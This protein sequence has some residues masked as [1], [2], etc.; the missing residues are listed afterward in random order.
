VLPSRPAH[1]D[2]PARNTGAVGEA[3]FGWKRV[4]A[5]CSDRTKNAA[6]A[7]IPA[8]GDEVKRGG[9]HAQSR[10][11]ANRVS[12]T[13]PKLALA[14]A[15]DT[16]WAD[17]KVGATPVTPL[18]LAAVPPPHCAHTRVSAGESAC[19]FEKQLHPAAPWSTVST[20]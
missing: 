1:P 8:W 6:E 19:R 5:G 9:R 2:E 7:P 15:T 11:G 4:R 18:D 12:S 13:I 14:G 17:L 16:D 20:L 10:F 3:C